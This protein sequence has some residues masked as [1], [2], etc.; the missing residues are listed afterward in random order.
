[1]AFDIASL[2]GGNIA[3]AVAKIVSLFKIDP[4]VALQNRT[5]IE[6]IQLELQKT[7][8]DQV[9]AQIDVDKT[10]AAGSSWLDHWRAGAGWVCVAGLAIQYIVSPISTWIVSLFGRHIVFPTLDFGSLETLLL[11][12]LGLGGMHMYQGL[13]SSNGNGNGNGN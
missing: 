6:K 3:D 13:K 1:M 4:T 10:E 12:M 9:G 2:I 11:G 8:I 7:I 5:D